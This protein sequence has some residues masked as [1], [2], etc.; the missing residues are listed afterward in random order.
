MIGKETVN[1]EFII[2]SRYFQII[3]YFYNIYTEAA[4]KSDG[5]RIP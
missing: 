3:E 1:L 5:W 4:I 2:E